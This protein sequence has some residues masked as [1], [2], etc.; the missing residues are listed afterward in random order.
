MRNGQHCWLYQLRMWARKQATFSTA[1]LWVTERDVVD[2]Q[3]LLEGST[4]TLLRCMFLVTMCTCNGISSASHVKY[5]STKSCMCFVHTTFPFTMELETY[6]GAIYTHHNNIYN[7]RLYTF[8][9]DVATH[10]FLFLENCTC[11][12]I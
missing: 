11:L 9:F 7:T 8:S 1:S 3:L 10:L 5:S 2:G 4:G 6:M 12:W